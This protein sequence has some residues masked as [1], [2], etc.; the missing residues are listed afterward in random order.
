MQ[1]TEKY[2]LFIAYYGNAQKGSER[3]ARELYNRIQ[4]MQIAPG[5]K[6]RVYF[7]PA[8]NPYGSFEETPMVV[9]RTPMFLLVADKNIPTNEMGQ[10]RRNRADG[11]LGNLF[12]EVQAFH[13]YVY[14]SH[15]SKDAAKLLITDSMSNKAGERLHTIFGGTNVLN[16]W[17]QVEE[18]I[19]SVYQKIYCDWVYRECAYLVQN[20]REDFLSGKWV[21]EA[22]LLWGLYQDEKLGR[23]LLTYYSYHADQGRR[24][25]LDRLC[26]LYRE[27]RRIRVRDER[28]YV[29]LDGIAR[30]YAKYM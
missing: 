11:T 10:L 8:T 17:Q 16:S 29:V 30:K 7:H 13:D 21:S 5:K 3:Q 28:T 19:R 23:T 1:Q 2:D 22:E 24:A 4:G 20:K 9:A 12:E 14:R 27:L 26:T 18:W 15:G 6:L 25:S